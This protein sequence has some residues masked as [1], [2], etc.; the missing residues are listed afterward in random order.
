MLELERFYKIRY[1]GP[2][3]KDYHGLG[4]RSSILAPFFSILCAILREG[5]LYG[6]LASC[7]KWIAVQTKLSTYEALKLG[8]VFLALLAPPEVSL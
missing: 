4:F 7:S 3:Q 8:G 6:S 2:L 1:F 5:G